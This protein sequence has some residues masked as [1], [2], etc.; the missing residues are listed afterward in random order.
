ME[1]KIPDGMRTFEI[2]LMAAGTLVIT[3]F[4]IF[5]SFVLIT[6]LSNYLQA[7]GIVQFNGEQTIVS[8]VEGVVTEVLAQNHSQVSR[9]QS[10]LKVVDD[11]KIAS[12]KALDFR[13]AYLRNQLSLL[14][15]L[16][17]A[18]ALD[19]NPVESKRLELRQAEQEK[20]QL[21]RVTVDATSDGY[22]YF[23]NPPKDIRGTFIRRGDVVGYIYRSQE[24]VVKVDLPSDW[25]DRFTRASVVRVYYKD[26]FSYLSRNLRATVETIHS[27]KQEGKFQITCKLMAAEDELEMFRPGTMV[28]VSFLVNSTS[29]FQ[30]MFGVDLYGPFLSQLK[31]LRLTRDADSASASLPAGQ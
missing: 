20:V 26:P 11:E 31:R 27:N 4:L 21:N 13:I 18:G 19:R 28:K 10:I 1:K 24:K 16:E 14:D 23:L 22:F 30:E 6:P 5:I 17:N 7:P 12:T 8:Q 25:V 3:L 2:R 15:K 29:I 9:K